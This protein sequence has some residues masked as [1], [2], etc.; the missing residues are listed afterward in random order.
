MFLYTPVTTFID[1]LVQIDKEDGAVFGSMFCPT[2]SSHYSMVVNHADVAFS[3]YNILLYDV[4][5]CV[6]S[7]NNLNKGSRVQTVSEKWL[8]L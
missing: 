7:L 6:F 3:I 2:L 5:Y 4:F 8:L 1:S